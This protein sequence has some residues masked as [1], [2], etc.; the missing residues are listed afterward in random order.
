MPDAHQDPKVPA[1]LPAADLDAGRAVL[2][3]RGRTVQEFVIACFR[4]LRTRPDILLAL[5]DGH[6]P[7]AKR[8]GRPVSRRDDEQ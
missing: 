5:L 8:R 3:Q 6:W 7:A 1:R 4:L 2:Q